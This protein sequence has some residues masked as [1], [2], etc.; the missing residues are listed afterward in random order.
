MSILF[1]KGIFSYVVFHYA[2]ICDLSLSTGVLPNALNI[3]RVIPVHK[4]GEKMHLIIID[5]FP[6]YH[7][8]EPYYKN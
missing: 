2:Y 8:V 3:A 5:P 6:Y 7:S 4:D 1:D